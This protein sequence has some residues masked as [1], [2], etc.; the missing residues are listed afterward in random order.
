[1]ETLE[2]TALIGLIADLKAKTSADIDRQA[3]PTAWLFQQPG[4][5]ELGRARF[6]ATGE[7]FLASYKPARNFDGVINTN[8]DAAIITA[9]GAVGTTNSPRM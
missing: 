3:S 5:V 6:L 1:M 9:I 2:R 4:S 7:L 8:N